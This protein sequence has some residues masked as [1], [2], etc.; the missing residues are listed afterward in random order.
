MIEDGVTGFCFEERNERQLLMV[1]ERFLKMSITEREKMGVLGRKL[2]EKNFDRD[3]V[4]NEYI[5][6]IRKVEHS[7]R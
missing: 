6:T 2:V 7:I 3:V 1:V 5:K 4:M